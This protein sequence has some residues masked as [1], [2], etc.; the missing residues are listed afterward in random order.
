MPRLLV[1]EERPVR[2][3][4]RRDA[5]RTI[6]IASAIALPIVTSL[7]APTAALRRRLAWPMG[8]LASQTHSAVLAN[9]VLVQAIATAEFLGPRFPFPARFS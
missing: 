9:V 6:G 4:S 1:E 7:V 5:I 2:R 3:T 8:N